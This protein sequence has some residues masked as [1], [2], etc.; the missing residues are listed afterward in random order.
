MI[1]AE[2]RFTGEPKIGVDLGRGVGEAT[3]SVVGGTGGT[4]RT[5]GAE[6]AGLVLV[7]SGWPR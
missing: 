5:G 1:D 3:K 2:F 7:F 6:T 4:G